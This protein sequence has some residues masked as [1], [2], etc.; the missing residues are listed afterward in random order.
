MGIGRFGR[1]R[2]RCWQLSINIITKYIFIYIYISIY[3][4]ICTHT[5]THTHAHAHTHTLIY[6]NKY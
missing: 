2:P 6:I 1:G 5:H 4:Y 3:L